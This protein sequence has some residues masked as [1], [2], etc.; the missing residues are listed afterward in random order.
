MW[1]IPRGSDHVVLHVVQLAE[2]TV[3]DVTLE[4]PSARVNVHVTFQ[5]AWSWK[6][7]GTE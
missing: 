1:G 5:I 2:T 3:A 4:R 7:L 6:G